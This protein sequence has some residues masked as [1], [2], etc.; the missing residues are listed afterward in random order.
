M[1]TR[2]NISP[3]EICVLNDED[4]VPL[5]DSSLTGVMREIANTVEL[6]IPDIDRSEDDNTERK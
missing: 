5:S 2:G 1:S 4:L 3:K 6:A